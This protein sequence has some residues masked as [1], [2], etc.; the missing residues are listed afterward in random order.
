VTRAPQVGYPAQD[1]LGRGDVP[2]GRGERLVIPHERACIAIVV[3]ESQDIV[4]TD[5]LGGVAWSRYEDYAIVGEPGA[6]YVEGRGKREMYRP[7]QDIQTLFPRFATLDIPD[8]E[9]G[10]AEVARDWARKYGVLGLTPPAPLYALKI[11]GRVLCGEGVSGDGLESYPQGSHVR[12]SVSHFVVEARVAKAAL[13]FYE[14]ALRADLAAIEKLDPYDEFYPNVEYNPVVEAR[15]WGLHAAS[16]LTQSRVSA[17]CSPMIAWR[18]GSPAG[19][20]GFKNLA[21]AM[22]LQM[23]F[24]LTGDHTGRTCANPDCPTPNFSWKRGEDYINGGKARGR[25]RR[26]CSDECRMHAHYLRTT[27]PRRWETRAKAST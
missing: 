6:L 24:N 13:E 16:V 3:V 25:Q 27:K 19:V 11:G 15:K 26:Y 4:D 5:R 17:W 1:K 18:G 12:D 21:G 7:L 14:A 22:W 10:Q 9:R 2:G 23:F 20:W 8:D